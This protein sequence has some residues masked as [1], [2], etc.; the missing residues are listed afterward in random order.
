VVT[1]SVKE[2]LILSP[3]G[4]PTAA[5]D[6]LIASC[7]WPAM[8]QAT[9]LR[10]RRELSLGVP[11]LSLI[12]LD[13][14]R[15]LVAGVRLLEW[16][17]AYH[18]TVRRL[19]VAY[20]LAADDVEPAIRSAGVHFFLAIDSQIRMVAE[21]LC[22]QWLPQPTRLAPEMIDPSRARVMRQGLTNRPC[23]DRSIHPPP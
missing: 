17:R 6:E 10:L 19:A 15:D 20:R 5:L 7:G 1:Q 18:P 8:L 12:W 23:A 3:C 4:Q 22:T 13:D 21:G 16:L 11:K 9:P 2:G 14:Y